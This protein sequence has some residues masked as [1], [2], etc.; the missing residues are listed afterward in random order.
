MACCNRLA[1]PSRAGKWAAYLNCISIRSPRMDLS[2]GARLEARQRPLLS[3]GSGEKQEGN[4][5]SAPSR[6]PQG[7]Q[8]SVGGEGEV[9]QDEIEAV[10]RE[11]REEFCLGC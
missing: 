9:G 2:L 6:L 3:Q 7:F 10:P 5:G 11:R 4:L 1:S 8:A